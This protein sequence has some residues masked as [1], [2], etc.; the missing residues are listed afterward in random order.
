MALKMNGNLQLTG[1]RG[2]GH[3]QDETETCNKGGAQISM[4]VS[5]TV[6]HYTGDMEPEEANSCSQTGT[7]VA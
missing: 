7:Q 5:L 1:I 3:L 6:T 4:G 2:R